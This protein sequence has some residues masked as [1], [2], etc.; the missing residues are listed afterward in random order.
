LPPT[1]REYLRR[2]PPRLLDDLETRP[3]AE[4]FAPA[5]FE[6]AHG[7]VCACGSDRFRVLGVPAAMQTGGGGYVLRSILRVWRELRGAAPDEESLAGRLSPP[8][9]LDCTR[10]GAQLRLPANGDAPAPAAPLEA[11]R[12]RPCRRSTFGVA[13]LFAHRDAE[14]DAP[15]DTAS[16]GDAQEC[17]DAWRLAVRCPSCGSVGEPFGRVLRSEQERRID[18]LYG[19]EGRD[20]RRS[21]APGSS[22]DKPR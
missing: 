15:L 9:V 20:A 7:L 5:P 8:L 2:H 3:G 21:S 10:C 17:Y 19:R 6:I 18:R 22:E 11:L 4:R 16:R 1:V 13:A 14:L 12:C